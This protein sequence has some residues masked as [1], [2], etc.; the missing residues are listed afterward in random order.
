MELYQEL[1]NEFCKFTNRKYAIAVNSGSSA[2]HLALLA[3]GVGQGDEVIVPDFTFV[4]CAFA[5][6]YTGATPVFV[7][8]ADDL[9]INTDLIEEKIT[10]KTKAIM[11]VH[12]YGRKCQMD[13]I[14][15]IAKKHKLEVI[16]DVS[17]S[18][19]IE[20]TA[21][22]GCY[23]FQES[24]IIHAEE[25]GMVV[26]N[27]KKIADDINSRK[28]YCNDGEYYHNKL[29]FN[30]RMA[31]SQA[32]LALKSLREYGREIL[33][34][35]FNEADYDVIIGS[36]LPDRDV[37]WIYDYLSENQ[38]KDI[39]KLR[40]KGIKARSFFKPMTTLPMYKGK[41]GKNALKYSRI[42]VVVPL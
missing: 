41:V 7:D 28:S 6:T 14:M 37:P 26:T 35:R 17:E 10:P 22:I 15:K 24:K 16:E 8:C 34:R 40:R 42:G 23:S 25:G 31:E 29:G 12:I 20:L 18:P 13:K 5:V 33:R 19:G 11:A 32:G 3:I 21:D 27:R 1:E 4:A 39:I 2:L 38:K 36:K 9:N 30:Y